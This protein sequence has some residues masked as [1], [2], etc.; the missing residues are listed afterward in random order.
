MLISDY[1]DI[2]D[3]VLIFDR[4]MEEIEQEKYLRSILI[5]LDALHLT[6]KEIK[7]LL[8]EIQI[9]NH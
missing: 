4:F 3:P 6:E 1:P 8:I 2:C 5:Y 9:Q 7:S